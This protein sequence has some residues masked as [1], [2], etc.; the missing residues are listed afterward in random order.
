MSLTDRPRPEE[1]EAIEDEEVD[2]EVRA[3]Y[4]EMVELG[5]SEVG[6]GRIP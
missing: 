1:D 5:A 2:D 3:H 6:E 4:Q